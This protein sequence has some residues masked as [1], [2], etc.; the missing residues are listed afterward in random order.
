MTLSSNPL[1]WGLPHSSTFKPIILYSQPA[2]YSFLSQTY[3]N[4]I[5]LV[6]VLLCGSQVSQVP[7]LGLIGGPF[8]SPTSVLTGTPTHSRAKRGHFEKG[9]V[10]TSGQGCTGSL[11]PHAGTQ[12]LSRT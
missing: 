2:L 6:T 7:G 8:L 10:K 9:A 3:T 4:K 5:F 11:T 1:F 12:D